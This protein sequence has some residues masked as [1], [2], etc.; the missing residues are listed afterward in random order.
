VLDFLARRVGGVDKFL[1]LKQAIIGASPTQQSKLFKG[2]DLPDLTTREGMVAFSKELRD[3]L[4]QLPGKYTGVP[5]PEEKVYFE[6][7][8]SGTTST[9]PRADTSEGKPRRPDQVVKETERAIA[10]RLRGPLLIIKQALMSG[11]ELTDQQNAALTYLSNLNRATF[12]EAL[13]A[14][15]YDLAYYELNPDPKEFGANYGYFGEGGRF[16]VNFRKWMQKNLSQD[17]NN[18]LNELIAEHKQTAAANELFAKE[19]T[20]YNEALEKYA[21]QKRVEAEKEK[22]RKK[23]KNENILCAIIA[24]MKELDKSGLEFVKMDA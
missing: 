5:V 24:L 22:K 9:R 4:S 14:L 8:K 20:R 19:I 18:I 6:R 13:Q 15:A 7:I 2:V 21:E 16:A 3:Y 12:G 11:V 23:N 17:T 1:A 10:D